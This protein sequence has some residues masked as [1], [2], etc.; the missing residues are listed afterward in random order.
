[1][2]RGCYILIEECYG[3]CSGRAI[4]VHSN[5]FYG[6]PLDDVI[7]Q[8]IG[9]RGAYLIGAN[10]K[11]FLLGCSDI[12][13]IV[14]IPITDGNVFL[15]R[16][17][18]ILIEECYGV[19]CYRAILVHSD[20]FYGIPLDNVIGL[21][22]GRLGVYLMVTDSKVFL[23]GGCNISS[24]VCIPITD[25]NASLDCGDRYVGEN[26][27]VG[28]C[29]AIPVHRD[30]NGG[31]SLQLIACG[32]LVSIGS[33]RFS[34]GFYVFVIGMENGAVFY[35]LHGNLGNSGSFFL[36]I[37]HNRLKGAIR[38]DCG[39]LG[40]RVVQLIFRRNVAKNNIYRYA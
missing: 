31:I 15:D 35:I 26:N 34:R 16:G 7:R 36:K 33:K 40:I 1:M 20:R 30:V 10:V 4:L 6:I 24:I 14:S 32:Q 5:R 37:E 13:S 38:I 18:Y 29:S 12:S 25:G 21:Q 23:L 19:W 17:C 11:G 39:C 2:D 8:Q 9:R 3:V 27:R 22:I 28:A